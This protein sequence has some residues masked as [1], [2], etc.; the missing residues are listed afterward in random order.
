MTLLG[1]CGNGPP[2]LLVLIPPKYWRAL[3]VFIVV[4]ASVVASPNGCATIYEIAF[5]QRSGGL[6]LV[7]GVHRISLGAHALLEARKNRMELAFQRGSQS[8]R[9]LYFLRLV[10]GS[11]QNPRQKRKLFHSRPPE[12]LA[13]MEIAL[14]TNLDTRSHSSSKEAPS[15]SGNTR[16]VLVS[17]AM[18][19]SVS[20]VFA[21]LDKRKFKLRFSDGGLGCS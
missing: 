12:T 1:M 21:A 9:L 17:T 15:P 16:K 13:S 11:L 18:L 4:G 10:H 19:V 6:T 8:H 20:T 7:S 14:N 2:L 3:S 5:A